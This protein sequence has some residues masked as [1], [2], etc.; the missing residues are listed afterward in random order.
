MVVHKRKKV[1]GVVA[2]TGGAS[3]QKRSLAEL[4]RRHG[5]PEQVVQRNIRLKARGSKHEYLLARWDLPG[6]ELCFHGV[7]PPG[8]D[9]KE[10]ARQGHI[11]HSSKSLRDIT[12]CIWSL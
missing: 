9:A 8:K 5:K 12:N 2:T 7:L 11:Y 3:E 6:G 1:L 10:P 4:A